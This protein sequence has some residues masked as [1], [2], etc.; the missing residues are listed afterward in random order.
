MSLFYYLF[1]RQFLL[2]ADT[3]N[4]TKFALL[5]IG[6]FRLRIRIGATANIAEVYANTCAFEC[7]KVLGKVVCGE[8]LMLVILYV[9]L[10]LCILTYLYVQ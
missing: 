10:L 6:I 4:S 2:F 5:C 9:D 1:T 8:M 7:S 3:K